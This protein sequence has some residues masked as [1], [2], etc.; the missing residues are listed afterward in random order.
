MKSFGWFMF[1]IRDLLK[2]TIF[3]TTVSFKTPFAKLTDGIAEPTTEPGWATLFVSSSDGDLK[4]KFGDGTVK[5]IV[6][7]T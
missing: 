4:I 1:Y 6:T 5:T 7:D 2:K 3:Q